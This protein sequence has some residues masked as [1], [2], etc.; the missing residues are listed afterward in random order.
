[1][2]CFENYNIITPNDLKTGYASGDL[3][4]G[5]WVIQT[6]EQVNLSD[7]KLNTDPLFTKYTIVDKIREKLKTVEKER[8]EEEK[9]KD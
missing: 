3:N 7:F 2:V 6:L 8:S 1:M 5:K 4:G 9:S